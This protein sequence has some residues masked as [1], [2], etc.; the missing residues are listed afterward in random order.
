[1]GTMKALSGLGGN[2]DRE[3]Y[4]VETTRRMDE[5]IRSGGPE[6]KAM[7][8][9]LLRQLNPEMERFE[10]ESEME[11]GLDASDGKLFDAIMKMVKNSG[12]GKDQQKFLLH[13]IMGEQMRMQ[14]VD[15]IVESGFDTSKIHEVQSKDNI[16]LQQ[17]AADTNSD[18]DTTNKFSEETMKDVTTKIGS[19]TEVFKDAVKEYMNSN[20]IMG[21]HVRHLKSQ[22]Q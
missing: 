20:N 16:N 3:D 6:A 14:D 17:R 7:K 22:D 1:M 2:F 19:L 10:L 8:M 4:T 21:E 13:S 15:T 9:S 18:I 5:G 11:K 12:G